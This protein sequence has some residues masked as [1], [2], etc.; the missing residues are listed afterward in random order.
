MLG[1]PGTSSSTQ[2]L[3][4]IILLCIGLLHEGKGEAGGMVGD[5]LPVSGLFVNVSPDIRGASV[6]FLGV[7]DYP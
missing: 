3:L 7:Y 5:Q 1:D 4:L 6:D 2:A